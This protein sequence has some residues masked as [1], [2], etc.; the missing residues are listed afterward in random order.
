MFS[1][2]VGVRF[3][4]LQFVGGPEESFRCAGE[5]VGCQGRWALKVV[6]YRWRWSEDRFGNLLPVWVRCAGEAVAV[7]CRG[8]RQ[9]KVVSRWWREDAV[10]LSDSDTDG[11]ESSSDC[12]NASGAMLSD[13]DPIS[14]IIIVANC[15]MFMAFRF[16]NF[17][18]CS[19]AK[20]K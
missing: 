12:A 9:L 8:R 18:P 4:N 13:T 17:S 3:W 10:L 7:D 2:G 14:A 20:L 11:V 19:V 15:S 1:N 16:K 5:A 6:S